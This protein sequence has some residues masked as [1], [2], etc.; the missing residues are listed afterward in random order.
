VYATVQTLIRAWSDPTV[1]ACAETQDI[2]LEWLL[3][4]SN[5]LYICAPQH[6]Q[7]RLAPVFGGLVGDL[8]QQAFERAGRDNRPLPPTLLI[9]DEAGNTPARWLPASSACA[10]AVCACDLWQS[11]LRSMPPICAS[12]IRSLRITAPKSSSQGVDP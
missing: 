3:S 8:V 6:E 10:A 2:D 4:G 9:L 5:T 11:R 1:C 12:R 7:A